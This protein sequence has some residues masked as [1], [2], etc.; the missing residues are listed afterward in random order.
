[1]KNTHNSAISNSDSPS[2][3]SQE[4]NNLRRLTNAGNLDITVDP[5]ILRVE[6]IELADDDNTPGKLVSNRNDDTHRPLST[7]QRDDNNEPFDTS[8][9]HRQAD[10]DQANNRQTIRI[11]SIYVHDRLEE[12]NNTVREGRRNRFCQRF[13]Q[14]I[15]RIIEFYVLFFVGICMLYYGLV[16]FTYFNGSIVWSLCA[17]GCANAT[18]MG[19]DAS[20]SNYSSESSN[21]V[22]NITEIRYITVPPKNWQN[23]VDGLS[24]QINNTIDLYF[25]KT[26]VE[27]FNYSAPYITQFVI[28]KLPQSTLSSLHVNA[29]TTTSINTYTLNTS[30]ITTGDILANDLSTDS[31]NA[32]FVRSSNVNADKIM[33]QELTTKDIVASTLVTSGLVT[34]DIVSESITSEVI[35]TTDLV[36]MTGNITSVFAHNLSTVFIE[37]VD[38]VANNIFGISLFGNTLNKCTVGKCT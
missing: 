30:S 12:L 10:D 36:A 14:N 25:N 27:F 20:G 1:M 16:L 22:R 7:T 29:L 17:N 37:A 34:N 28:L 33:N 6:E 38:V 26:A 4:I 9:T 32:T 24:S 11:P 35:N 8:R 5:T 18:S 13:K 21:T 23:I 15:C 3:Q 31:V 19:Y 2:A